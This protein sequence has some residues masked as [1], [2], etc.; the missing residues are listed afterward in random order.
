MLYSLR[1]L[2]EKLDCRKTRKILRRGNR[3]RTGS[4]ERRHWKFMFSVNMKQCLAGHNHL[5]LVAQG[6][7]LPKFWACRYKVLKIV[8]QQKSSLG[9][10]TYVFF[11]RLMRGLTRYFPQPDALSNRRDRRLF[12]TNS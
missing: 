11:Q 2:N 7:Q 8:Q 9:E 1:A 4:R 3:P 6:E 5:Q 12:F 10:A